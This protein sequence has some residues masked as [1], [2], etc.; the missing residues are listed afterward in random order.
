VFDQ[1]VAWRRDFHQHPE[2]SNH[3]QRTGQRLSEILRSLGIPC[4]TN[5]AGHG[6]VAVIQGGRPGPCVAL[7][8]DMDALPIQE[9]L[10][11]P[12]RSKTP[13]VMH[14]CGHDLHLAAV[15]G[16]GSVLQRI[17]ADLTGSVKLI[18][19]PAEEGMP[20]EF[21]GDWGAKRMVREGVLENPRPDAIYALHC[22]P[23]V[24]VPSPKGDTNHV[25]RAGQLAWCTGPASANS[26]RFRVTISGRMAHGSTPHR[27]VDAIAVAAE[28]IQSLQLIRSRETD[29]QQ[30]LVLTVGM[31]RGGVRENVLADRVEFA[32][33]VRTCDEGFRDQVVQLMERTL[34]GV[35]AAHGAR[36]E[37]EYRRG[38]PAILNDPALTTRAVARLG[39]LFGDSNLI[40]LRP[41]MG[42]EDF[43]YFSR[44]VP[45]CY[46]RLGVASGTNAA[47][48]HPHSPDF[49]PDEAA[50]ETGIAALVAL[51]LEHVGRNVETAPRP[52]PDR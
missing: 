41:G 36:Y 7:R 10:L 45:G 22:A 34:Q 42:G 28:A 18:F 52:S 16:A 29:T 30:P 6:V 20:V 51:A 8:A 24:T 12:F 9:S 48:A 17:R 40:P 43:S 50:L 11:S 32:G 49:L 19:Q 26:D 44:E 1:A 37:M 27:G 35:T 4:Q 3:E 13:G 23:S 21:T 38:Y 14:A 5:V 15:L 39:G 33:T 47:P 2:L 25:L 46:L 31:I